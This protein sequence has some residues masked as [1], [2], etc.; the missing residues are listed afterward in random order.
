MAAPDELLQTRR[1]LRRRLMP[2]WAARRVARGGRPSR[3]QM[4]WLAAGAN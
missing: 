3:A 1:A 4:E 2:D